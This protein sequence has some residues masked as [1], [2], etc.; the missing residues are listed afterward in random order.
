MTTFQYVV[1]KPLPAKDGTIPSGT[2]VDVT[3]WRNVEKL[4]QGRYLR[5]ATPAEV[6]A[7]KKPATKKKEGGG[8]GN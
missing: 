1:G 5:P 6:E 4:V 7:A 3:G 2:V 8:N